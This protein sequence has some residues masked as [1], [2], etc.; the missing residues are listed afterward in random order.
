MQ[1]DSKETKFRRPPQ[2]G[3]IWQQ[4]GRGMKLRCPQC[5]HGKLFRAYLKPVDQCSACGQK[6]GDVRADLAPAW[7]A[8]T[9]SAHITVLIWHFFFWR[10]DIPDWQLITYLCMIATV[11]CLISLPP[12]KGLFMA[13]I[14]VKGTTDS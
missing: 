7:A 3:S 10:A 2:H 9:I 6:W 8:M 11:I 14:W 1:N 12:L 4:L 13:I 5:G